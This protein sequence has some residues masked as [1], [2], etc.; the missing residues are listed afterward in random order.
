[1]SK[2][3]AYK[4]HLHEM[5]IIS[6]ALSLLGWDQQTHMPPKGIST[7]SQVSGRLSKKLFELSVAPELGEMIEALE[8]ETS[9]STEERA[10]VRDTAKQ[11]RRQKA[12]PPELVEE[13]AM[14]RSQAQPAWAEARTKAD[15]AIFQP[16]LVKMVDY[17]RRFADFFGYEEHPYDGLLEGFE[18]GM[19]VRKLDGI[20]KP[21]REQLVPFI[22]R[23]AAEG[24]PP[25]LTPIEGS[26][27]VPTQRALAR[28]ALEIVGYDFEAGTL[29]DVPH[30]FTTTIGFN[31]VRVTNRY[32]ENHLT[33]GLYGGLHEGGHALYN[34]GMPENLYQLGLSGGASNGIH[35]SQSRMIENQL[36]RSLPFWKY[37]QPILAEF[38]PQFRDVTPEALYKAVNVVSPSFI[39]VE[40]DEVTYNLH[41]MLRAELEAGLIAGEIQVADLPQRWNEAMEDYVGITPTDD[42]VGVLQDVHWSMGYFGY[43]PSYMLGNL[44][45]SQMAVKIRQDLP[46][47]DDRIASGDILVLIDWLRT[48]VH[49]YGGVYQPDELMNKITGAS[50]D[51]SH[52]VRYVEE[53]Y[54]DIYGLS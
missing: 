15:F 53:K 13:I 18:P 9:L 34:Q 28:R 11:Y 45:A 24:T 6:S 37:F 26:F 38:F 43:F 23:L 25:D 7:R 54:S 32:L 30:P 52:F 46:D 42:A 21:L 48:N 29:D 14:A 4:H 2:L 19:T 35:E 3:T 12:I 33:S 10:S 1:L 41:I 50:L 16:H 49:Q 39:R 31:D 44:Y 5:S 22:K 27:D 47:L 40:A 20:I 17:G 8:K 51:A 36:G